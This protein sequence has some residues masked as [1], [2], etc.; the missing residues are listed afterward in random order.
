MDDL[1]PR[2]REAL[3]PGDGIDGAELLVELALGTSAEITVVGGEPA[4][5]LQGHG[6][7]A[8]LLRY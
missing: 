8:A 5:T 1:S 4:E 7:A 3:D 6:G 2:A